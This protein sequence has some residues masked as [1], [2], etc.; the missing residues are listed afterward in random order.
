MPS[1]VTPEVSSL[2]KL[3]PNNGNLSG[4]PKPLGRVGNPGNAALMEELYKQWKTDPESTDPQWRA[5]FEG[6]ELGS[7]LSPV[8]ASSTVSGSTATSG[9]D[10]IDIK[11][12]KVYNFIFAYRTLGHMKASLDPL[13][14]MSAPPMI[15]EL[16]LAQFKF[17]EQDLNQKFDSGKLQ[18]GGPKTLREIVSVLEKTYCGNIGVEYMHLQ[19]FEMRRWLRDR[20]ENCLNHPSFDRAQKIRILNKVYAAEQFERFLHTRYVGQKRFSLEGGETLIAML[21][22]I[23]EKSPEH[24]VEQLVMGMAHRGRLNVLVN[25]MG[26]SHQ[27]VFNEFSENY[28]PKAVY[29]DGD[30]KYHLGYEATIKTSTGEPV[31]VSLAPNPSHLEAVNPVVEGQAR[32]RQHRIKNSHERNKVVPVLIHGDAAMI[33]QGVVAETLNLSQLEGYRTG[34]TIHIV[35]NN[36]IGFTTVPKDAR[37]GIYCTDNAKMLGVPIFHVNGDDPISAVYLSELAME[38]RQKFKKDIFIDLV[39]YRRQGHNE[40]DEPNFTQPTLYSAIEKHPPVSKVLEQQLIQSGDVTA[41]EVEAEAQKHVQ[42]MNEEL[43]RAKEESANRT[44]H[45]SQPI[46]CPDLLQPVNTK[47]DRDTYLKVG[48]FLYEEPTDIKL[49]P[50]IKRLLNSRRAM[51][52]GREPMDWGCAELLAYGT[53]VDH[54]ILVRLSG[55]DSR[56]GTFSHRHAALYDTDTRDRDIPLKRLAPDKPGFA[57]YNSPL[58][59]AAV[60]G[61]EFGFS[62]DCPEAL[63]IWEAQFGD[64]ANGA[65]TMIDQYITSSESKWGVTSRIVLL[66]PHG[67]HGQG[68]EHSSA[69]L[70]RFLQACAEDNIQVANCTTPA[71]FF[72]LL[73]RQ[74]LRT[75]RKPLIVMTPK[76]LLRDKRATSIPDD[77]INGKFEEIIADLK[78]SADTKRLILCSGKVY[79]DLADYRTANPI[80]DTAILRFEQI[81]PFHT[82]KLRSIVSKFPKLDK[83]VWCQEESQNMGAWTFMEPRLREFF[84]RPVSYAG[85]DASASPATGYLAVH[86]LEQKDLVK[87]AFTC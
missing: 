35:I 17:T 47:I 25:T 11:Q 82:E 84:G 67:Y 27:N 70:E 1:F 6:F 42:L 83:I 12:A 86:E 26:K 38:F 50:K 20:M 87:Q 63:I 7:Q 40:G 16:D 21:D 69:R 54:G 81:Y 46:S 19:D 24:G 52:E 56:R 51:I 78:A 71:S 28:I 32:A 59:E 9:P 3:N 45:I 5:F 58:S 75:I 74:A 2:Q 15:K 49:N 79:Y 8:G 13:K 18:G 44:A 10:E 77:L 80:N 76:G 14:L 57:V 37:S 29:G 60:L 41:A 48:K 30:V 62:L 31:V 22:A 53:L 85:R 39:C 68:P 43:T 61:F 4:E 64:F 55:Q 72:H 36:Q 33:G 34:G 73:R 65:Q 23:I 66:L